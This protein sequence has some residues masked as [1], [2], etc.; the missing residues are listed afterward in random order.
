M[1]TCSILFK[2]HVLSG[3]DVSKLGTKDAAVACHPMSL[4][5]FVATNLQIEA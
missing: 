3:D 4:T 1:N 5:S 2:A